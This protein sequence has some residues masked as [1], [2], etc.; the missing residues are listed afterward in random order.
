MTWSYVVP[1]DDPKDQ[2]RLL[3]GDTNSARPL[4]QDEEIDFVLSSEARVMWAAAQC[5]DLVASKYTGSGTSRSIGSMSISGDL[6]EEYTT[7]GQKLRQQAREGLGTPWMLDTESGR[8]IYDTDPD[9]IKS[10]FPEDLWDN[11][12]TGNVGGPTL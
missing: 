12:K 11:K 9:L 1:L 5:C 10:A 6:S 7:R 3:M 4:L 8:E 2:V